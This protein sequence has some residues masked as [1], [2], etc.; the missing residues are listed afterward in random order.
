MKRL[1]DIRK[2]IEQREQKLK[3]SVEDIVQQL[4]EI[5]AIKIILFGSLSSN[6][7]NPASDLD[8]F[9]VMPNTKSGRQWLSQIYSTLNRR[10]STD[11]ITFNLKEYQE[12]KGRNRFLKEITKKGKVIYEK[13]S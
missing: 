9:V 1:S 3:N 5:G 10:V 2:R 12:E 7:I 8:I 13:K 11:I 4:K 6:K